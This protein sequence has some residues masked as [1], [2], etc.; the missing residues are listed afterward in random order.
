M[1][2]YVRLFERYVS[3]CAVNDMCVCVC[4]C[5]CVCL[6]DMCVSMCVCLNDMCVCMCV[7]LNA[8][9]RMCVRMFRIY[10]HENVCLS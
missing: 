4:V 1:R 6:N 8:Y 9:V 3:M 7:C 10:V 2:K 5:M